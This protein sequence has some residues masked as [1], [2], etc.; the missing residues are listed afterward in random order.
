MKVKDLSVLF[1]NLYGFDYRVIGDLYDEDG[2]T[3]GRSIGIM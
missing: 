2:F 1:E 3:L